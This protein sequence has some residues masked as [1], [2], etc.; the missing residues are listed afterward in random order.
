MVRYGSLQ[1]RDGERLLL[2]GLSALG[3]VFLAATFIPPRGYDLIS[4]WLVDVDY[5]NVTDLSGQGP[6]R[7]APPV[8]LVM[9]PLRSLPWEALV[10][11]WLALQ[12]AALWYIGGRWTL[13]LIVFPPVWLD[14]VYG[15]INIMLA[16]VIVAGFRYPALW[17]FALLTKVTPGVGLVWFAVRREWRS[18]AIALGATTAII[19]VSMVIQGV[20]AWQD[21]LRFLAASMALPLPGDAL[22]I[23]LLPRLVVAMLIVGF[24]GLTDRRWLVPL[25]VVLAMPTLW[26]IAFAPLVAIAGI[27]RDPGGGRLATS[28]VTG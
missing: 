7:Y 25:G 1:N 16:A 17:S 24:A 11:L 9:A 13:A 23:P 20:G 18:L 28:R 27:R 2:Y 21:W 5:A 8:A 12:L 15:N 14:L 4:Y 22:P 6:F 3:L 10:V 26:V 19:V